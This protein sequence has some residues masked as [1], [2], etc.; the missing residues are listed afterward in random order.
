MFHFP[1]SSSLFQ[2]RNMILILMLESF[3]FVFER[4]HMYSGA[5]YDGIS[6]R[7]RLPAR[8]Y[9]NAAVGN[10]L[11][12]RL[13]GFVKEDFDSY[14]GFQKLMATGCT[15]LGGFSIVRYIWHENP[16]Q[17]VPSVCYCCFDLN[18]ISIIFH[19]TILVFR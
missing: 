8:Y 17:Q 6:R 16:R 19:L 10:F 13:F 12:F 3:I 4:V 18:Y 7:A 15:A 1:R 9:I 2:I 5:I 14:K 11:Q